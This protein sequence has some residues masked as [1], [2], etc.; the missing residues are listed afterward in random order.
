M[1]R[2]CLRLVIILAIPIILTIGMARVLTAPWFIR[3][4]YGKPGFPDDPLGLPVAAR[5]DLARETVRYLNVPDG[6]AALKSLTLPDGQPAYNARELSHLVDV[7]QVYAKL[8][9]AAAGC[10]L[11]LIG[12]IWWLTR[13]GHRCEVWRGL[14]YGGSLTLGILFVFGFWMLTSFQQF[15]ERFHDLF[16]APGTWTFS[17]SDTLIRLFPLPLWQDAGLTIAVGVS[18][19][20]VVT[21]AIG[22]LRLR[23][24]QQAEVPLHV[25]KY[26]N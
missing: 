9:I 14:F 12:A 7:K 4:E 19:L 5:W 26:S 20:A 8:T 22:F 1:M 25:R 13:R 21:A 6:L 24:C 23:H 10:L 2:L 11:G 15:F 3:W 16:F 17:Y 18:L